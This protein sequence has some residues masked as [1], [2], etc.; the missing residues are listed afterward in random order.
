MSGNTNTG[1]SAHQSAIHLNGTICWLEIPVTDVARA[2]AFYN[3]VLGWTCLQ[4]TEEQG[5]PSP[6]DPNVTVHM[7]TH[8]ESLHGAFL[9]MPS[10]SC[11]ADNTKISG[12]VASFKVEEVTQALAKVVEQEGK[13]HV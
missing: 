7:F 4:P 9:R 2:A 6:G 12:V 3:A 13:V 5:R 10:T 8:G 1:D 11:I